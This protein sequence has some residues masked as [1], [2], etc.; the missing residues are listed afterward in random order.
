M[1]LNK[2]YVIIALSIILISLIIIFVMNNKGYNKNEKIEK[3]NYTTSDNRITITATE[4]F[5]KKNVSNYDLYITKDDKQV[6]GFFTYNLNEYEENNSKEILYKQIEYFKNTRKDFKIFK[7]ERT[8][9]LD[10][11]KITKIEYSGIND[12]SSDCIYIFA[13]ID[14]KDDANYVLYSNEVVL[15]NDYEDNIDNLINIIKSAKLN[16]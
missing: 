8:I 6:I 16:K 9:Y 3:I 2:K 4:D 5:K 7:K 13:V 15:N 11:K 12:N 1:K 10:D 14:F